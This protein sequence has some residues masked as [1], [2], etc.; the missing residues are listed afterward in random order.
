MLL[1]T[2][3]MFLA[4]TVAGESI[5][6]CENPE[7]PQQLV[8]ARGAGPFPEEW[9][10]QPGELRELVFANG[11]R[12]G[13]EVAPVDTDFY[14]SRLGEKEAYLERVRISLYDLRKDPPEL[15]STTYGGADSIQGFSA[16][17]GANS[18]DPLG[19]EKLQL[20]LIKPNC[21]KATDLAGMD[22]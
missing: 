22:D 10:P 13:V 16:M 2:V 7:S 12:L 15:L 18:I 17:G 20:Q 19:D 14:H 3:S 6:P 1:E 11:L 4:L 8:I 9:R 5:E 21:I